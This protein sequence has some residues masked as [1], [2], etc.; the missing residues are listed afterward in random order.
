M[1]TKRK[2]PCK[3]KQ[4]GGKKTPRRS[5]RSCKSRKREQSGGAVCL[6]GLCT[7]GASALGASK[8]G[9]VLVSSFGSYKLLS[10]RSSTKTKKRG[11]RKKIKRY[12]K[13]VY[14]DSH[15]KDLNFEIKQDNK[16]ITIKN[17]SKMTHKT[18][19]VLKS[20]SSRYHNKIKECVKKGFD[21]C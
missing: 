1:K 20:A 3:I 13:F 21:K 14:S 17:G 19:K 5:K 11:D 2:A 10:S 4:R 6:T 7:A 15:G 16:K 18:Y 9:A 8:V 12:Q